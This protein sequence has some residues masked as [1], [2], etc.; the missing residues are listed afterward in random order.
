MPKKKDPHKP[1]ILGRPKKEINWR[2]FQNLCR[3]QCTQ[4]EIAAVFEINPETL[5]L[6]AE[7]EYK[8]DFS[9]LYKRFTEAGKCSLRRF[10]FR[11]AKKNAAMAIWLGKQWLGQREPDPIVAEAIAKTGFDAFNANLMKAIESL[12]PKVEEVEV[13][14]L[15]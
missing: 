10:Q 15:V 14:P 3:I 11:L 2:L 13:K 1:S 8:T 7:E 12:R 5:R 6:R 9:A 4:Q